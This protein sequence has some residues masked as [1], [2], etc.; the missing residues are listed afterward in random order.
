MLEDDVAY[1]AA[2]RT[3]HWITAALVLTMVPAGFVMLSAPS[4]AIQNFLFDYHRSCGVVL[5]VLTVAR[6]AWRWKSPPAAI[7]EDIPLI[8]RIVARV[9]HFLL[10]AL[11]L[12]QPIVGWIG[13]SA[14]GAK[15]TVFW[16]FV[17]PPIVDK[18]KAVADT[19]LELH[20]TLGLTMTALVAM[21]IAG[22]LYHHFIRRD[23]TLMRMVAGA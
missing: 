14:F 13:T 23:R 1:G 3:F 6:L 10:Y 21:H 18:D 20:E 11:L 2:A 4:G 8:Q 15:I 17:L 9:V 5:F 16:L 22:A 19:F 12:V 7:I